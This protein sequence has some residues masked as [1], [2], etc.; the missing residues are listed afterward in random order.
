[1]KKALSLALICAFVSLA[2]TPPA[3]FRVISLLDASQE[4]EEIMKG[5]HPEAVI[6][7]PEKTILPIHFFLQ[8][9]LFHFTESTEN[10]GYIEVQQT[11]YAR[12]NEEGEPLFSSNL[13]EWKTFPE[14]VKGEI[15]VQLKID[16]GNP[17]I[18][19]GSETNR[20]T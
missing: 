11:F 16:D 9:N 5:N 6:A 19:L 18:T 15:S 10:P 17:S 8:G 4:I 7:F 14:F 2:A 20:K 3:N 1:M 12:C 13:K